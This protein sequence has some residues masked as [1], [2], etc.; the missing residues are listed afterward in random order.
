MRVEMGA[1][2]LQGR[3]REMKV[4]SIG[5]IAEAFMCDDLPATGIVI[6]GTREELANLPNLLFKQVEIKAKEGGARC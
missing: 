4:I 2:A 6:E 5:N 3:M 1:D